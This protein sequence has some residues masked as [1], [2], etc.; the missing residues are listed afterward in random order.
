MDISIIVAISENNAIG[1]DNQL[2][3]HLPADLKYFKNRTT[4]YTVIMGR[5]TFDSIGKPLPNRRN[6]IIT[7]QKELT[8]SG[9]EVYHSLEDAIAHCEGEKEIFIIGGDS[10]YKESLPLI[11][12]IYLTQV[13][14]TFEADAFFPVLNMNEW[15]IIKKEDFEADE[16]NKYAYSF[17]ELVR[18]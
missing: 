11:N 4:G 5:K 8:L 13:H 7:R 15:N 1:K 12:K 14:Q 10:I 17:L 3:W 9:C 6:I 18:K 2:L 16:K